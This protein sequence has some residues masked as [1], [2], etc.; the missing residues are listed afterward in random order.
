MIAG[1][2]AATLNNED[3]SLTQKGGEVVCI[4]ELLGKSWI[5]LLPNFYLKA[6]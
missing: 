2:L 5:T 1:A 4:V 6:K 3:E